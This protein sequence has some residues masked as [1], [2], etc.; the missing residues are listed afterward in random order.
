MFFKKLFILICI[1]LL[2]IQ[3]GCNKKTNT[4]KSINIYNQDWTVNTIKKVQSTYNAKNKLY[5]DY[6]LLNQNNALATLDD[7]W[8]YQEIANIINFKINP[9]FIIK[10]LNNY[11]PTDTEEKIKYTYLYKKYLHNQNKVYE[12]NYN[13]L[14]Q[15]I[16][17]QK[18]TKQ[19]TIFQKL[20]QLYFIIKFHYE[21]I[22]KQSILSLV[23]WLKNNKSIL[24]K[25][26]GS[27]LS[28]LEIEHYTNQKIIQI[29]NTKTYLTQLNNDLKNNNND[30]LNIYYLYFINYYL[31]NNIDKNL[32]LNHI[33]N[34]Y[35]K[36][37]GFSMNMD[38]YSDGNLGTYLGL[39]ILKN[40]NQI[41]LVQ[42]N[43]SIL[44]SQMEKQYGIFINLQNVPTG[45][46]QETILADNI[47]NILENN[48]KNKI[49]N[50][51]FW[52]HKN[53]LN[54]HIK[55]YGLNLIESPLTS[56]QKKQLLNDIKTYEQGFTSHEITEKDIENL[57]NNSGMLSEI[58]YFILIGKS[59]NYKFDE[60]FKLKVKK[61]LQQILKNN[62]IKK[63][64]PDVLATVLAINKSFN[65]IEIDK[66]K[67]KQLL[68]KKY[69]KQKIDSP[70][71]DVYFYAKSIKE[72]GFSIDYLNN[73]IKKY[74]N[75]DGGVNNYKNKNNSDN[76]MLLFLLV[77][78]TNRK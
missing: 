14:I 7:I 47:L 66:S 55:Y 37:F 4:E 72:M 33:L 70:F 46:I 36:N 1:F 65:S 38:K 15:S 23:K 78:L 50:Q 26:N 29:K 17:K 43:M 52:E 28:I 75:K 21:E 10:F 69:K 63:I 60:D 12:L 3:V 25:D 56:I 9:S 44:N 41:T 49:S 59:L 74:L 20:N 68:D 71:F 42:K 58:E 54:W 13:D 64:S 53:E 18:S 62:N 32:L 11:K 8:R 48:K 76:L 5:Y 57:L 27:L 31:Q 24:I 6:S 73:S 39:K 61:M 40:L 77:D 35:D 22:D 51:F 34:F 45:T 19:E 16:T 67:I 2:L 30:L